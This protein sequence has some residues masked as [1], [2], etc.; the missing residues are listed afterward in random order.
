[1]KFVHFTLTFP[2][3]KSF[4]SGLG[5]T[6]EEFHAMTWFSSWAVDGDHS[7]PDSYVEVEDTSSE[8]RLES[9]SLIIL[10]LVCIFY[11]RENILFQPL[12][13]LIHPSWLSKVIF[14]MNIQTFE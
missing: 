2:V 11:C 10:G 14:S 6:E 12:A 7:S 4:L 3:D 5:I 9:L 13:S 8:V 1:L